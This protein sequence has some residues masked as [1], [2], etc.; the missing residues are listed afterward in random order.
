M[1]DLKA[2]GRSGR[3]RKGEEGGKKLPGVSF[4]TPVPPGSKACTSR[5]TCCQMHVCR[6]CMYTAYCLREA[7]LSKHAA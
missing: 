6:M 4:A 1:H 2:K 5:M 3:G 7:A